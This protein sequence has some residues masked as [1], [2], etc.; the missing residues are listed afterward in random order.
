MTE[1]DDMENWNYAT[2]AS[3]GTIARRFPYHYKS[4]L[5]SESERSDLIPGHVTLRNTSEQNPRALYRRWAQY[6]D[7]ADWSELLASPTA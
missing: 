2:M 7:A 4:G 3:T 1:Q 6:M 5:G